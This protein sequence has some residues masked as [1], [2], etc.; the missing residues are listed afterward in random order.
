MAA[1]YAEHIK[2][3]NSHTTHER[4]TQTS[5]TQTKMNFCTRFAQNQEKK[6]DDERRRN[7][8]R[9]ESDLY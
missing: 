9:D 5:E 3:R 7:E 4:R 8:T 2:Y 1:F 6:K